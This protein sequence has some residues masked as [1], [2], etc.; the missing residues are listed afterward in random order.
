[1]L[2]KKFNEADTVVEKNCDNAKRLWC[3]ILDG[4]VHNYKF[5][6]EDIITVLRGMEVTRPIEAVA[7]DILVYSFIHSRIAV[8]SSDIVATKDIDT[9][10]MLSYMFNESFADECDYFYELFRGGKLECE[11]AKR[12]ML[13]CLGHVHISTDLSGVYSELGVTPEDRNKKRTK[14]FMKF[15]DVINHLKFKN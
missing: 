8:D 11:C 1:M 14:L 6:E 15:V 9:I 2:Y 10:D 3:S 13:R 7:I 12:I 5:D 4:D